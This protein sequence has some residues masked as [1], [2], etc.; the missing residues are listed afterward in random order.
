MP[1][2]IGTTEG[3]LRW[4][5]NNLAKW[6]AARAT[7][8]QAESGTQVPDWNAPSLVA[9]DRRGTAATNRQACANCASCKRSLHPMKRKLA[10]ARPTMRRAKDLADGAGRASK[11]T[12]DLERRC[13]ARPRRLSGRR[14]ARKFN[15]SKGHCEAS[16]DSFNGGPRPANSGWGS[17][18]PFP[19][20][21]AALRRCNQEA[22]GTGRRAGL[23]R[24]RKPARGRCV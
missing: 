24:E 17:F 14:R 23:A 8:R 11:R 9:A 10:D 18:Q 2:L 3:H 16:H 4:N 13:G 12:F 7:L 19:A 5:F 21:R 6:A 20:Q 1:K 22:C 15:S